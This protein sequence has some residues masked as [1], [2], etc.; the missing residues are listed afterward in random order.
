MSGAG[1]S[2]FSFTLPF[3]CASGV[4]FE[5]SNEFQN[6]RFNDGFTFRISP[7]TA[8]ARIQSDGSN[9]SIGVSN[10]HLNVNLTYFT[11]T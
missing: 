11:A 1:G 5:T 4:N 3:T 7:G 10:P 9:T 8:E 2:T 6:I